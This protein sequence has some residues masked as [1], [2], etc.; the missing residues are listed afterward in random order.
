MHESLESDRAGRIHLACNQILVLK[1]RRLEFTCLSGLLWL[2]DGVG[3][4]RV[5]GAGQHVAL[6]SKGKICLQAFASS[7]IR[8]RPRNASA[9]ANWRL[10]PQGAQ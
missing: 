6:S 3:G 10:S 1:G 5:V 9:P 8:I 7:L 2:T 4:E